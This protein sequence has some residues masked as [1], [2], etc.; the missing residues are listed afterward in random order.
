MRMTARQKVTRDALEASGRFV[1]A[2][3]LHARMRAGGHRIGLT[4]VYGAL[5]AL[6]DHGDADVIITEDGQRAC[7][8]CGSS[9]SRHHL[10]CRW[11]GR[12]AELPAT[13]LE[14]W[15]PTSAGGM[16]IR[17]S[18]APRKSS[19]PAPGARN[20]PAAGMTRRRQ[21]RACGQPAGRPGR[22]R[23][24]LRR[25]REAHARLPGGCPGVSGRLRRGRAR[26]DDG[27]GPGSPR[28]RRAD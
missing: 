22:R 13:A 2:Q 17:A 7:R 11:C 25:C 28:P 23:P 20:R 14:R 8:V 10:I 21:A 9:A 26:R 15:E 6:A 18:A 24:A 5:R 1:C 19:G 3:D 12:A 27:R 4:T 16:A